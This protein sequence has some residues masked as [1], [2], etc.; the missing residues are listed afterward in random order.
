[1][2]ACNNITMKNFWEEL[3]KGFTVLAPMEGV[4]NAIFRQV[5]AQAGR[6]DV[7]FTE[8]TNVSSYASEKGRA[9]ALERLE[10]APRSA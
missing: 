8:F 5:I 4:T 2:G 10:V 1:M 6:P 9:N 7:F 3:P